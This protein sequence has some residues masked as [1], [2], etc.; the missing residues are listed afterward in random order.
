M[1]QMASLMPMENWIKIFNLTFAQGLRTRNTG[2]FLG[3]KIERE[4]IR[5]PASS[6]LTDKP[7]PGMGGNAYKITH[8]EFTVTILAA[9]L[10]EIYRMKDHQASSIPVML[11]GSFDA[12][13]EFQVLLKLM[14]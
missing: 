2:E 6:S 4:W 10:Q 11:T 8:P 14:N 7:S 12:Y 5:S 3:T 13:D 9:D 1:T